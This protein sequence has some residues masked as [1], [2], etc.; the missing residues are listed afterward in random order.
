VSRFYLKSLTIL[1]ATLVIGA[2]SV[3]GQSPSTYGLDHAYFASSTDWFLIDNYPTPKRADPTKSLIFR[4]FYFVYVDGSLHEGG[5]AN[6]ISFVC[7]RRHLDHI[8]IHLPEIADIKGIRP[9]KQ[10]FARTELRVLADDVGA[11]FDAEYIDGDFFVDFTEDTKES[12]DDVLKSRDLTIEFGPLNERLLLYTG[13]TDPTGRA[14]FKGALR[15]FMPVLTRSFGG[16]SRIFSLSEMFK[17]CN[18][19]KGPRRLPR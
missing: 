2:G 19:Y 7:Q 9:R 8:L 15:D 10:W 4:R 1:A 12:L 5:I 16:K 11:K 17:A 6:T 14:N 3:R 13:D 18:S